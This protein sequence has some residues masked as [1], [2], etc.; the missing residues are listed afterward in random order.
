[1]VLSQIVFAAEPP[2][3][4]SQIRRSLMSK[5]YVSDFEKFMN[6]YLKDHPE[7]VKEQR[8]GWRSFWEVNIDPADSMFGKQD[9]LRKE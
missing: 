8:R 7:V 1:M 4:G 6:Q 2:S 5:E 3:A 9:L